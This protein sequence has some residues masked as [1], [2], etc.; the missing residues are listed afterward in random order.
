MPS[1]LETDLICKIHGKMGISRNVA[2]LSAWVWDMPVISMKGLIN[3]R[4]V[5]NQNALFVCKQNSYSYSFDKAKSKYSKPI[6]ILCEARIIIDSKR[7][8][9]L[10]L[11]KLD[12]IVYTESTSL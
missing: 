8:Y 5:E 4:M 11:V 6:F 1:L 12:M 10:A 2:L 3:C 9:F 7:I